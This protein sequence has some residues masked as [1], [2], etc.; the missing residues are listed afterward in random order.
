[1]LAVLFLPASYLT[2]SR[3]AVRMASPTTRKT[4]PSFPSWIGLQ[5]SPLIPNK[6]EQLIRYYSN[7]S[8]GKRKKEKPVE[9][10]S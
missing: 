8:R 4:S 1:V 7:V 5:L 10:M 6:G 3:K 2:V 9:K